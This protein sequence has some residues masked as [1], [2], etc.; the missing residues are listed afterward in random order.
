MLFSFI[1]T[2]RNRDAERVRRCLQSLAAQNFDSYEVLLVDYGSDSEYQTEVQKISTDLGVN[3]TYL[4]AQGWLWCKP[5]AL[6]TALDLAKGEYLIM[7][8]IDMIYPNNFL[9]VLQSQ[10]AQNKILHY[11]CYYLSETFTDY[12]KLFKDKDLQQNFR[13]SDQH[14]TG[15]F[16]VSKTD[17]AEIG[18]SDEFYMLWGLE[19][20]DASLRLQ[21][22]GLEI[23]WIS[24]E[25]THVFHQWHDHPNHNRLVPADWQKAIKTY[26]A[27]NTN[28]IF[29]EKIFPTNCFE[30]RRA[31]EIFEKKDFESC[32]K[33]HLKLPLQL[34]YTELSWRLTSE[35]GR[36]FYLHLEESDFEKNNTFMQKAVQKINHFLA[37][38]TEYR[39]T[40]PLLEADLQKIREWIFYMI[41]FHRSAW[42]DYYFRFDSKSLDW[43]VVS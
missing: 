38:R 30:K 6:N 5:H 35:K 9:A 7:V 24:P 11:H 4:A 29:R 31:L 41:L 20:S 18:G 39:L 1:A 37:N 36:K 17:F 43:V 32:E 8:D 33:I 25:T 19:D 14:A 26:F 21:A 3:Y 2:Y 15:L 16:V 34:G 22:K 10:I 13:L 23:K 40:H 28:R 12:D 42:Q 27:N